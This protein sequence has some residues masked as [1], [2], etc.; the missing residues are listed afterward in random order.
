MNTFL[1]DMFQ[2][3]IQKSFKIKGVGAQFGANFVH[4]S[5]PSQ[6]GYLSIDLNG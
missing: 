3:N 5:G 6:Q 2:S 4:Q 1:D